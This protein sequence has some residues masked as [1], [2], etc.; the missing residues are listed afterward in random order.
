MLVVHHDLSTV[1]EYFDW[2]TLLNVRKIASGP[3]AEVFT[4][5][6][7]AAAYGDRVGG[8]VG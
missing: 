1:R 2:V 8:L 7:L 5:A 3:A 6:N 4:P